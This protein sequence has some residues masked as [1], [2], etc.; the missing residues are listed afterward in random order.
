MDV[1]VT[2]R[3]PRRVMKA[4]PWEIEDAEHEGIPI[5]DNHAPKEFLLDKGRLVGV[6]FQKMKEVGVDKSGRP[7]LEPSGEEVVFECDDVLMA[8]GQ[9]N[10]FPW[11]ERNIGLE[12]D[13]WGMPKVDKTTMMST[14]GR[15]V[16][17]RRC[18]VGP[19]EHHLG[20]RPRPPGGPLHRSHVQRPGPQ[21]GT[22]QARLQPLQPEDGHPRVV[23]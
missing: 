9:E 13:E 5:F 19:G 4:S 21:P 14:Q 1:K 6:R 18:R 15:R 2:V 22:T 20:G 17:R 7:K 12:F 3:S 10:S 8:I 11:I 16:L 23:L